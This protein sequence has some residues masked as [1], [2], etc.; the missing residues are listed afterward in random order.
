MVVAVFVYFT[1]YLGASAQASETP[2]PNTW[3]TNGNVNAVAPSGNTVYIGGDFNYIG[4]NTG[5][6]ATIDDA[7][8]QVLT[9]YAKI[10]KQ[11]KNNEGV[12]TAIEGGT[13]NAVVPDGGGGWYIGGDFH[14]VA[15]MERNHIAHILPDGTVDDSWNPTADAVVHALA[16]SEDG[17]VVYVGGEFLHIGG[18]ARNYLAALNAET[19]VANGSFP[20]IDDSHDDGYTVYALSETGGVV[21]VGGDFI[22]IGGVARNYLA[23]VNA[24]SGT[25][26]ATFADADPVAAGAVWALAVSDG[27]V[28]AG[29]RFFGMGGETRHYLAAIDGST[30]AVKAWTPNPNGNVRAL[31]ASGGTVYVGGEFRLIGGQ[32]KD[33]LAAINAS[34][35]AAITSWPTATYFVRAL[36]VGPDPEEPGDEV[37]YVGGWFS[38]LG[39][40]SRQWIGGVDAETSEVTDW[41]PRSNGR[42]NALAAG[43]ETV[44]AGGEFTSIGGESRGNLA[45]IDAKTGIPTSWKPSV[46]GDVYALAVGP[47]PTPP[48]LTVVYVGGTLWEI[49]GQPRNY[50]AAINEAGDVTSW[51]PNADNSVF[52]LVVSDDGSVVYAGG[53]FLQIGGFDRNHLAAITS[54]GEVDPDWNPDAQPIYGANVH[55]LAFAR[56][57]GEPFVYAGGNFTVMGGEFRRYIAKIDASGAATSWNLDLDGGVAAIEVRSGTVYVGGSFTH[58]RGSY[59]PY[60]AAVDAGTGVLRPFWAPQPNGGVSA[61]AISCGILYVGGGFSSSDGTTPSIGGEVRNNLAALR[62]SNGTVTAWNPKPIYPSLLV[63][64]GGYLYAGGAFT[65]AGGEVQEHL[66]RFELPQCSNLSPLLLLLLGE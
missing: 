57:D 55:A 9:P 54:T 63:A 36:A 24:A 4:P 11:V 27:I 47:S 3:I 53:Y 45:A 65:S 14:M 51:N 32:S 1:H 35:G 2:D 26:D 19:G 31:A 56:I 42:V 10:S 44:Y 64:A 28:Y 66:A 46:V 61:L 50:L 5:G 43:G 60:L 38:T 33:Y 52:S 6:G 7:T 40:I 29:G 48:W 21:Y 59:L 62:A 22:G 58:V 30:G 23:A 15:G 13:V 18:A 34:T 12:V 20:Q 25:V 41:A 16:V 49:D 39:G 37:V 8:G 17:Q